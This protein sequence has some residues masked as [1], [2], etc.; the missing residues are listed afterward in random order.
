MSWKDKKFIDTSLPAEQGRRW[1]HRAV[2]CASPGTAARIQPERQATVSPCNVSGNNF[3]RCF[4]PRT[5]WSAKLAKS[6]V[7]SG[8]EG[9]KPSALQWLS[10]CWGLPGAL[11]LC[12]QKTSR[13]TACVWVSPLRCLPLTD[14]WRS[15]GHQGGVKR[16]RSGSLSNPVSCRICQ[17]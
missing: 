3:L 16:V 10:C 13:P 8:T 11:Q 5:E 14:T 1:D 6:Q 7:Q 15:P 17:S 9:R 2:F 12:G 4:P